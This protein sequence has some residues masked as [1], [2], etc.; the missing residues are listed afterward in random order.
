M[1]DIGTYTTNTGG[2][3]G[4][5]TTALIIIGVVFITGFLAEG[6][7]TISTDKSRRFKTLLDYTAS[8]EESGITIRQDP[9]Y[10]D[11]IPLGL[12]VNERTGIEFSYS[13]YMYILPSTFTGDQ[14]MKHVFHKGFSIPWPLMGP[15]VFVMG[16]SNTL[17][18]VMNTHKN[19]YTYTDVQ[20]IP[21][22]KWFHV[23]LNCFKGGL[24]IYI[25]GTLANRI[26]FKDNVPYQ[27]YQDLIFFSPT[28]HTLRKENIA[29]LDDSTGNIEIRGAF[30]GYISNMKYARYALSMIEIGT[31]MSEGPS[32]K[33]KSSEMSVPPYMADSWW[34]GARSK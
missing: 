25:N 2:R 20:N 9:K 11:A 13:F 31:L 6:L 21:V 19:P 10:S 32:S 8:S 30:N 7:L 18:V 15:G 27:N 29:A 34:V 23:V 22:Q 5:V 17:R 24:D 12:S 1:A 4:E 16:N 33:R 28:N 14:V 26:P 3:V